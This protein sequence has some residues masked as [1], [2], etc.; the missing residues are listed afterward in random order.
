LNKKNIYPQITPVKFA[1]L[2]SI[3]KFNWEE[4]TLVKYWHL[5]KKDPRCMV[6]PQ[7]A[8]FHIYI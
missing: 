3:D 5:A 1:S 8:G 4:G 6:P 2:L 7:N